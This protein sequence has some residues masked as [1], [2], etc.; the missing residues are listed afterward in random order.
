MDYKNL[1]KLSEKFVKQSDTVVLTNPIEKYNYFIENYSVKYNK[2]DNIDLNSIP[3]QSFYT[4]C[5]LIQNKIINYFII[6]VVI[7]G[8]LLVGREYLNQR[9]NLYN[10]IMNI[11]YIS[12]NLT[13]L[14]VLAIYIYA[15]RIYKNNFKLV[16]NPFRRM[17]FHPDICRNILIKHIEL[18]IQGN[19]FS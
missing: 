19:Y 14:S 13:F 6:F 1:K 18:N 12:L 9:G 15:K 7:P 8:V 16:E 10:Y 17:V 2:V 5:F 11:Y 4:I 3:F